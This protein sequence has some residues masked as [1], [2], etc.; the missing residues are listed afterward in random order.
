LNGIAL[1][2]PKH[3]N[4]K[5]SRDLTPD[6]NFRLPA[7]HRGPFLA[8]ASDIPLRELALHFPSVKRQM[9][10]PVPPGRLRGIILPQLDDFEVDH[11][12][13]QGLLDAACRRSH[14]I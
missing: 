14:G 12:H 9:E 1:Y 2:G 10:A 7:E 6:P 3:R 4:V 13:L 5:D 11:P 8:A